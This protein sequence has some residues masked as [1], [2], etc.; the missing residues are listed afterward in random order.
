MLYDI[1]GSNVKWNL[2]QWQ[3]DVA[4]EV[5]DQDEKTHTQK[6]NKA[7]ND[8]DLRQMSLTGNIFGKSENDLKRISSH[9]CDGTNLQ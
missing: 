2:A 5:K 9:F 7:G 1:Y 8:P 4:R 6:M 3:K